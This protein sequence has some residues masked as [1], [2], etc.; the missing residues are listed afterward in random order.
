MLGRIARWLYNEVSLY[1]YCNSNKASKPEPLWLVGMISSRRVRAFLRSQLDEEVC[2][3]KDYEQRGSVCTLNEKDF[4][5]HYDRLFFNNWLCVGLSSS[6]IQSLNKPFRDD[7]AKILK[8]FKMIISELC[9]RGSEGIL[10][11]C[12]SWLR[13]CQ[14]LEESLFIREAGD[15]R[16]PNLYLFSL[17]SCR[18][19]GRASRDFKLYKRQISMH[20]HWSTLEACASSLGRISRHVS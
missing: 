12:L 16:K 15:W 9:Y 18:S 20:Y 6:I 19:M 7:V 1:Y 10:A 3:I 13:V 17:D 4:T 11:R 5:S 14:C 2:M 8:A